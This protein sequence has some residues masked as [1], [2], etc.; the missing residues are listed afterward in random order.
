VANEGQALAEAIRRI[1][2]DLKRDDLPRLA[3]F[4]ENFESEFVRTHGADID[5]M[6]AKSFGKAGLP[7]ELMARLREIVLLSIVRDVFIEPSTGIVFAGFGRDERYPADCVWHVSTVAGGIAKRR[8]M[9]ET[10]I[11]P[12]QKSAL[13]LYA[14]SETTRTLLF[15]IAPDVEAAMIHLMLN[16]GFEIGRETAAASDGA[17]RE[18]L[19]KA[20]PGLVNQKVL[21]AY[22]QLRIFID[23]RHIDPLRGVIEVAQGEELIGIAR[24]LVELN[25][26]K[27][28]IT[29]AAET[30]GGETA[31]ALITRDRFIL[32]TGDA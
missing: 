6:L 26:F 11:A 13:N 17:K 14:Q 1:L 12:E 24:M 2:A 3:C 20:L 21:D 18:G 32:R 5:E 25:G 8:F 23:Q 30:V 31:V 7:Q 27:Q 15:G 10:R 29:G 19:M 28:R 16:A 9:G 4:P 22:Q